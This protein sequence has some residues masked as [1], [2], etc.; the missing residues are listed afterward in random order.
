[1]VIFHSYFDITRGYHVDWDLDPLCP[2]RP[3]S[4]QDAH[5][6]LR[7]LLAALAD[8]REA[9]RRSRGEF[10]G[11]HPNWMGWCWGAYEPLF[12]IHFFLKYQ[13]IYITIP[14]NTKN[15]VLEGP[16]NFNN[17]LPIDSF[18]LV[19]ILGGHNSG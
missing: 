11:G 7:T 1:M 4:Q 5:E 10:S 18:F 8:E 19:T 17:L 2:P 14:R 9:T 15:H 13:Y 16:M 12:E 3:R 6:L